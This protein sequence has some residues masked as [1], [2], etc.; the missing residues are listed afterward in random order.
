[1]VVLIY[2]V[3][4]SD[5]HSLSL[6]LLTLIITFFVYLYVVY[7]GPASNSQIFSWLQSPARLVALCFYLFIGLLLAA[8]RWKG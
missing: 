7:R 4:L 3:S 6:P 8:K 1:M 5:C 2:L